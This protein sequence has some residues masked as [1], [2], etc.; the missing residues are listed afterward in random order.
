VVPA[1]WWSM[2]A[3]AGALLVTQYTTCPITPANLHG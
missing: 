2:Q 3:K 1:A